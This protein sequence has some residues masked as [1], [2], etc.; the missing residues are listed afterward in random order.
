M[1]IYVYI[2]MHTAA[3]DW[4]RKQMAAVDA[5]S[6]NARQQQ[7]SAASKLAAHPRLLRV[8]SDS[9]GMTCRHLKLP[10]LASETACTRLHSHSLPLSPTGLSAKQ[11]GHGGT[12]S[13]TEL[14]ELLR[15]VR[16]ACVYQLHVNL[17]TCS[18]KHDQQHPRTQNGSSAHGSMAGRT[19]SCVRLYI[20]PVGQSWPAS[21]GPQGLYTV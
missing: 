7:S 6:S 21:S 10:A 20:G 12:W 2:Y 15:R 4:V 19:R 16:I 14:V 13:K 5:A 18:S 9:T 8:V 1:Y 3:Q 11:A 17:R